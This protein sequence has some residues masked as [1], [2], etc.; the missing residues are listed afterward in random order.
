MNRIVSVALAI[1]LALLL[2]VAQFLLGN[3]LNLPLSADAADRPG[4][5]VQTNDACPSG[6]VEACQLEALALTQLTG[7]IGETLSM[8]AYRMRVDAVERSQAYGLIQAKP[9]TQFVA[10]QVIFESRAER[11]V[12]VNSYY[13]R[14][15]DRDGVAYRSITG[16]REPLLKPESNLEIGQ[17]VNGWITF[18]VL[19]DARDLVFS[20]QIPGTNSKIDVAIAP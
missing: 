13:A 14:L 17:R 9:G 16:G 8:G 4:T 19:D 12:T 10:V 6:D 11:D 3:T 2:F 15:R 1:V 20:Y 18:E 7:R 5:V